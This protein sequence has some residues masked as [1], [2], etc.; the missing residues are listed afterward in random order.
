MEHTEI[1]GRWLITEAGVK[2]LLKKYKENAEQMVLE[3]HFHIFGDS[4]IRIRKVEGD[5]WTKYKFCVK[6]GH[7]L[8]RVEIEKEINE[9]S[10]NLMKKDFELSSTCTAYHITGLPGIHAVD[11]KLIPDCIPILEVEFEDE[12]SAKAFKLSSIFKGTA[13]NVSNNPMYEYI[14]IVKN[15]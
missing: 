13:I 11:L 12:E 10:F 4:F 1:E 2:S 6:S 14:N 9:E 5:G 15:L 8:V 3:T 7:G